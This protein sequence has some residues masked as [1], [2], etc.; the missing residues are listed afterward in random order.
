MRPWPTGTVAPWKKIIFLCFSYVSFREEQIYFFV[1]Y[2]NLEDGL[3]GPK[4]ITGAPQ[5]NK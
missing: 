5:N 1:N 3:Q 2:L 4:Y